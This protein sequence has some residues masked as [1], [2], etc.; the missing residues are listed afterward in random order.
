M[1]T[2]DFPT[3]DNDIAMYWKIWKSGIYALPTCLMPFAYNDSTR[4]LF[5]LLDVYTTTMVNELKYPIASLRPDDV[6]I[7]YH[8]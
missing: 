1:N 2:E 7:R 6:H 8:L 5:F 4:R 3:E